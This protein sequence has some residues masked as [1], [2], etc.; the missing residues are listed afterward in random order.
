MAAVEGASATLVREFLQR[1]SKAVPVQEML[2]FWKGL[3]DDE[4][5]EYT[6]EAAELS[7][8]VA[9]PV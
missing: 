5:R 6:R 2:T 7:P 3:T 9:V 1:D 4:K 8:G